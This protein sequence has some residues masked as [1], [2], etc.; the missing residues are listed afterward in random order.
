MLC[1]R[2]WKCRL[3]EGRSAASPYFFISQSSVRRAIGSP[4]RLGNRT[5]DGASRP[6]SRA[7]SALA[8]SACSGCTPEWLPLRR[9][10]MIRKVFRSMS[11]TRSSPTSLARSPC[12]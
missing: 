1:F 9:W 8:S 3:A 5:G 7:L 12:R 10:T 4:R 2:Q 11:S 6:R